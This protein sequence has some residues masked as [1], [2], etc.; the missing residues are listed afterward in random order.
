MGYASLCGK[1]RTNPT[2]PRAFGTCDRCQ[3][4]YNH[5]ELQWQFDYRGRT[6]QNLRILVCERCLD[7]GQPQLKPRIIPVDPTPIAN[8]RTYPYCEA[9]EDSR[10]TTN[11]ALPNVDLATTVDTLLAGYQIVDGV[12]V[13]GGEL[14][15]VM[16]Q[17]NR[18]QNG[19]YKASSGA[20]TLQAYN[21]DTKQ[22]YSASGL[23][24]Y[25]QLGYYLGAVNVSRGMTYFS[26]LFQV[27]FDPNGLLATGTPV[28]MSMP[29]AGSVNHYDF[30]T[31]IY[32]AGGEVRV[33][34]DSDV[35]STQVVGQASGNINEI[36]GFSNLI[37]GSCEIGQPDSVPYGC[38]TKQ[39]LPPGFD[40]LPYSGALW[41]TLQNQSINVWLNENAKPFV[42]VNVYGTEVTFK[43]EGFWPN[44]GPGA[45]YRPIAFAFDNHIWTNQFGQNDFWNN[46]LNQ[47]VFWRNGNIYGI[48]PPGGD[49]LW[50]TD[51][52]VLALWHNASGNNV[53]FAEIYPNAIPPN[54][55]GPW[56]WGWL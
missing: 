48:F 34:Q 4:V 54:K 44:P 39:G 32:C 7:E 15:L 17:A 35:R 1:A 21:N 41:P 23:T 19:I 18:N 37:P 9:E 24:Y 28:L 46:T 26:K 43:S 47:N 49:I 31:G 45:P 16:A 14:I 25:G 5:H 33:T 2:A 3:T 13:T 20:W 36:P 51:K 52:C 29:A 8:A 10:Y 27:M 6:L 50:K 53:N 55:S 40:S 42:W 38:G 30:Y 12:Q 56:P 11:P 22:W